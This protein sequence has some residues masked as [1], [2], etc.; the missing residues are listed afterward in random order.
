MSKKVMVGMSGGVDSSVAAALLRESGYEISGVTLK[1]FSKDEE[2]GNCE[3]TCCSL[4]DVEDAR[5]VAHKM[6]FEHYVFNF[7]DEFQKNV[8]DKFINSYIHAETPNPCIDCN[9][10]I[11]FSKMLERARVLGNEYIA[12][13]HYAQIEFDE[14]TGRYVLKK[15]ADESKD[16]TYVLYTLSQDELAHTLFPLGKYTKAEVRKMAEERGLVNAKKPDSQDIC[17]V[18][19]G[20][21]ASF[22][23]N[24]LGKKFD[25]GNFVDSEGN[26]IGEHM[27]IINYTIGQRKGL[28]ITFGEPRY[29]VAK[30]AQNNSV[31]LGRHEELFSDTLVGY[32]AN[33]IMIEKLES[34]MRVKAKARY[35]QPAVDAIISPLEDGKVLCK[36]DEP[37][38]A[39]SP[40]QAVVFYD[41]DCVVGGATIE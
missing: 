25:K 32:D 29:V 7:K 1:L 27:G 26:I 6:G 20:D 33:W 9:R 35:K 15:A 3:R 22:I 38:R 13:G 17:F 5:F 4:R 24:A 23:E 18:P 41:G 14:K 21:Y 11:K 12:T 10:Y 2:E 19:D 39:I 34:P 37:Q 31:T 8:I 28:G 40:G 36:F 30:N 16:Q